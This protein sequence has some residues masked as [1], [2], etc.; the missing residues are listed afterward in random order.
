MASI[1]I[2]GLTE[3][4]IAAESDLIPVASSA[5][6]AKKMALSTL[7]SYIKEKLGFG[8]TSHT[9][10]SGVRVTAVEQGNIQTVSL[11]MDVTAAA[12]T[13]WGG[14]YASDIIY[15]NV[16]WPKA[17]IETP[18]IVVSY[19]PVSGGNAFAGILVQNG[20]NTKTSGPVVQLYRG[21][22]ATGLTGVVNVVAIGKFKE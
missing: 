17:F 14:M 11:S 15:C 3:Q 10:D 4:T 12:T 16:V 5:G 2:S 18:S 22:S 7:L 21:T 6:T 8:T 9:T 13:E 19:N 1:K 20:A